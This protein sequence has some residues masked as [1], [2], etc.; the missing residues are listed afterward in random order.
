MII[1]GP[2]ETYKLLRR[3]GKLP[4][5]MPAAKRQQIITANALIPM[6]R[7]ILNQKSILSIP[8]S[9]DDATAGDLAILGIMQPNS[10]KLS[11]VSLTAVVNTRELRRN[12]KKYSSMLVAKDLP[13][14]SIL[15]FT[16]NV[17]AL[18]P[19]LCLIM[20]ARLRT[21]CDEELVFAASELCS[22]YTYGF[23]N[24]LI[25]CIPLTNLQH[26]EHYLREISSLNTHAPIGA[27]RLQK[28]LSHVQSGARSP[29]EIANGML[30]S[31]PVH[32]GGVGV[33]SFELNRCVELTVEEQKE[34]DK[35]FL[36]VDFAWPDNNVILEYNGGVHNFQRDPDS[37]R[38]N[39]LRD[40]GN[41][42][43]ILS[44]QIMK[45]PDSYLKFMRRLE[46]PLGFRIA[47]DANSQN[48][49]RE[50]L[51]RVIGIAEHRE[52]LGQLQAK[53]VY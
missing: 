35:S 30:M 18:C 15:Q 28:I 25:E 31:W 26:I 6:P 11:Q 8:P 45:N 34:L 43:E 1:L 44:K 49:Q 21:V 39:V 9:I 20:L 24:Q 13:Q 36:E 10:S 37:A 27:R 51:R 3:T 23:D 32:G 38:I 16:E 19:A 40:K 29:F 5:Q 22:R 2:S 4:K 33:P 7:H 52:G 46:G 12:G 53:V 50:L 41:T 14:K 47:E 17:Y 42:V 48:R